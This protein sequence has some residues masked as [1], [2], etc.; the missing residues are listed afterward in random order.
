MRNAESFRVTA[1]AERE[2]A[3]TRVFDAPRRL[4]FEVLTKPDLLAAPRVEKGAG[5]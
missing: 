1:P 2:I 4:V 5:E 3:M